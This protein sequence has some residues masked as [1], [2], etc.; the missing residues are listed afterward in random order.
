VESVVK[1]AVVKATGRYTG[2]S[3]GR[4]ACATANHAWPTNGGSAETSACTNDGG[5]ETASANG[6]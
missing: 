6:G 2:E 1:A 5:T 4:E 3:T